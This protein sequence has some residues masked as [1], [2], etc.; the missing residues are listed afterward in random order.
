MFNMYHQ[1]YFIA[2]SSITIGELISYY[3]ILYHLITRLIMKMLF[4]ITYFD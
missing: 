4:Y 1:R 3:S 2:N